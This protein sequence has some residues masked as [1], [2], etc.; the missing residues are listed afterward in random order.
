MFAIAKKLKM[1]YTMTKKTYHEIVY[2]GKKNT[3]KMFLI[4][5]NILEITVKKKSEDQIMNTNKISQI[6]SKRIQRKTEK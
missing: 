3:M 1:F 2:L 6:H 5:Q 4:L